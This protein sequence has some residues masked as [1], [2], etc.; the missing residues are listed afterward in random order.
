MLDILFELPD[1]SSG[2]TYLITD[3]VVLG[4][5]RLFPLPESKPKSA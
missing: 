1:Q 4:R 3:D 5:Q 2:A